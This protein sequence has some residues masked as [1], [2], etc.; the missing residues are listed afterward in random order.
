VRKD[1]SKAD[2]IAYFTEKQDEYKLDLLEGLEDGKITFY[3]QGEFT[4]LCRGPHIPDT[5]FIKAIKLMNIAGAY[6][7]GDEK[8][9]QLTRIYGITFTKAKDLADYLVLLRRSQ[10]ARPPQAWERIRTIYF[11][12]KSG[13]GLAIVVAKRCRFARTFRKL[14]KEST[15]ESGLLTRC[16][17]TYR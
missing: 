6:W 10:K 14:F 9:K 11:F 17:A 3:T 16:D 4:D 15:N 2:A 5:S 13:Y 1:V 12:G 8:N 7:R